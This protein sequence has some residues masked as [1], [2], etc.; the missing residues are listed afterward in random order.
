[1]PQKHFFPYILILLFILPGLTKAQELKFGGISGVMVSKAFF[2]NSS[3]TDLYETDDIDSRVS[4]NV[5]A[6][7]AYK[8]SERWG[9]SVEPGFIQ[10]GFS[11]PVENGTIQGDAKIR[12]NYIQLPVL[13]EFYATKK[14]YFSVGPEFAYLLNAKYKMQEKTD[15]TDIYDNRFEVS[16]LA[17]VNYNIYKNFDIGLRYSRGLTKTSGI[18]FMNEQGEYTGESKEFNQY[19]QFILKFRI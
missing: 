18:I 11:L 19:L 4:F 6:F 17:G 14:L 3:A 9:I 15:I 16:G 5:N 1:M 8:N 2:K 7:V 10:K 12:L 13:A